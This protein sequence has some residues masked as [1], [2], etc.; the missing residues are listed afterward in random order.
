MNIVSKIPALD[1]SH[2]TVMYRNNMV[3][4]DISVSIGQGIMLGIIGP[5]GAGKTTFIKSL[6]G[7]IPITSGIIKIFNQPFTNIRNKIAYVAQRNSIDW[8][9]PVTVFDMVLMGCYGRLGWFLR[10]SRLDH[11]KVYSV[12][13]K[14]GLVSMANAPIGIL[15]GGQ[16]QRVFLARALMQNADVFFLDEP[17]AGVDVTTEKILISLFKE[18]CAQGKTI[19]VVHHDLITA[20]AYFDSIL[21]LNKI[22]IAYGTT[23]DILQPEL[24]QKTYGVA[25]IICAWNT[26]KHNNGVRDDY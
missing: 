8:D 26:I 10:P 6:L 20:P 25:S 22:C 15:S 24:L 14:V 1:V 3:L 4:S 13:E 11:E 21:L 5:N 7:L 2:L 19:V 17:F 16:Q 18:L 9:F 23:Q 12:L